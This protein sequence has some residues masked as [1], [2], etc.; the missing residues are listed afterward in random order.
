MRPRHRVAIA[1]GLLA[2]AAAPHASTATP[3]AANWHRETLLGDNDDSYFQYVTW[4][5]HP[6][7]YY[8]YRQTYALQRISKATLEVLEEIPLREVSYLA[9]NAGDQWVATEKELPPFDLP[10]YLRAND[11]HHAFAESRD[12]EL[13]I[14]R[15]GLFLVVRGL[16]E[17]VME[18]DSLDARIPGLGEGPLVLRQETTRL[19]VPRGKRRPTYWTVVSNTACGDDNWSEGLLMIDGDVL[20]AAR[21]R[22]YPELSRHPD[23]AGA[24]PA[25][26][27]TLR[28]SDA[29]LRW[30]AMWD[31]AGTPAPLS[32]F[33]RMRVLR[34]PQHRIDYEWYRERRGLTWDLQATHLVFSPD[35]AFALDEWLWAVETDSLGL[36]SMRD[37]DTQIGLVEVDRQSAD[38]V[39]TGGTTH[40]V[41]VTG[42]ASPVVFQIGGVVDDGT[43][44][45][46]VRLM[47]WQGDLAADRLTTWRGPVVG[48]AGRVRE[49]ARAAMY[50]W[51][52]S[53]FPTIRR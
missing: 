36:V 10:A 49:P 31:S 17:L 12:P 9:P 52:A 29:V 37:P 53:R 32:A 1:I 38:V 48:H 27:D 25:P 16:R 30:L 47:I 3:D 46:E 8:A 7:S 40:S 14:S 22:M 44:A 2:T 24:P 26:P 28:S 23:G 11:V 39:L 15:V 13:E 43:R 21:R 42:W 18:R 34:I 41:Q 4:S 20:D 5:F 19:P 51:T 6:G 35:S 50:R 33:E 45:G